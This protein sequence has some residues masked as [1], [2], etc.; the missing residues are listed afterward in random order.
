MRNKVI[1][2]SIVVWSIFGWLIFSLPS[3]AQEEQPSDSTFIDEPAAHALYD[4]MVETMRNAATMY[5]ESE[6]RWEAQ[7][8]ELGHAIYKLWMKKPNYVRLEAT[9]YVGERKGVFVGDGEHSWIY[10]PTGR[11][12]FSDDNREDYEKTRFNSYMKDPPGYYSLAH[13][14]GKLGVGMSMTVIDPSTFHG[15]IDVLQPYLDGV[16]SMGTEKAGEEECEVIEVSFMSHQRSWYLWISKQD[17]IP[18][19]L[20]AVVRGSHEIICTEL[21]SSVTLNDEIPID[22]FVWNPPE[23]WVE[24]K[25]PKKEDRL[26]ASGTE[27]PNFDLTLIDGNRFKLSD[28]QG[29]VVWITFWRVGCPACRKEIHHL[30]QVYKKYRDKGLVVLGFNYS[31]DRQIALDFLKENSVTF[32]NIVDSSDAANKTYYQDY[33]KE[34]GSA[35]PLTYIIDREGKVAGAFY[36]YEE[37]DKRGVEILEKLGVK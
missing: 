17:Y 20:K 30:K 23:D 19:K 22:K 2:C 14:T 10:W 6:Y 16:R 13:Q 18:R 27:T 26:L 24:Y 9:S 12:F 29:E 28:Y 33:Q 36:G 35:V 1:V 32:L 31:D 34:K 15:Y 8:K 4:K 3:S 21:W 5:Y 25:K 11:P 37:D 7:E